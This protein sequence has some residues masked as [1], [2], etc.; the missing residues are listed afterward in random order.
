M[1]EY[2]KISHTTHR[3]QKSIFLDYFLRFTQSFEN[4]LFLPF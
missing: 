3:Q 2:L 4:T 1:N